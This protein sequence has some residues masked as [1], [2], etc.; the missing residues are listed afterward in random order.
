MVDEPTR[1]RF[2]RE[3][4]RR[5]SKMGF[6]TKEYVELLDGTVMTMPSPTPLHAGT[7][8]ILTTEIVLLLRTNFTVRTRAPLALNN[9]S[10]PEPDLAICQFEPSDYANEPPK[11]ED[12]LLVIEVADA[13]LDYDRVRKVAAYAGSGIPEYWIVN[14][15]DRRIEVFSDPDPTNQRYRYERIT[16]VD[17]TLTLPGG[18]TF[19]VEDVLPRA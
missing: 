11:A 9:W 7:T 15:V 13:T 8:S 19:A 3:E 1:Y 18:I 17:E 6:F 16:G 5:L 14:M 12:V 10:E 4:Y 2:T